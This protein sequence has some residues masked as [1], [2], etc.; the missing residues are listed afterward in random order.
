[1][2]KDQIK[3]IIDEVTGTVK[4]NVGELTDNPKLQVEGMVQQTMGKV[5]NTWGKAKGAAHDSI[6]DTKARRN[7]RLNLES[8][9][10]TT[11]AERSASKQGGR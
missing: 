7:A 11:S 1:V 3:G 5:Q 2:N 4:R 9:N 8:K 10:A 6:E